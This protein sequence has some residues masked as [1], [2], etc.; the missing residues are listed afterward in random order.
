M[1]WKGQFASAVARKRITELGRVT[2]PEGT[3]DAF[4]PWA[5][6]LGITRLADITGLDYIGIPVWAAVMPNSRSLAVL[7]G[8]GVTPEAARA[9]ALMEAV[10]RYHG[11][12]VLKPVILATYNDLEFRQRVVPVDQLPRCRDGLFHAD[13]RLPWI[14][15]ADLLSMNE[16]LV[17][18]ELVHCDYTLPQVEGS[19]C[20]LAT[21]T[22]LASGNHE[23][24]ASVAALAEVIERDAVAL[25]RRL[26]AQQ[27]ARRR[28]DLA[29]VDDGTCK[30][31]L[32]L[33]TRAAIEVAVWDI[34]SNIGTAAFLCRIG[35]AS[36]NRRPR[37]GSSWG[38]G[39]HPS[40][41][42]ALLRALT[43]AAQSR[44]TVIAGARDDISSDHYLSAPIE[45]RG[46]AARHRRNP[47]KRLFSHVPTIEHDNIGE[48]LEWMIG[49][50]KSAGIHSVAR[51]DLTHESIG[52]PV[53]RMVV[54]G[55]EGMSTSPN[56][57]PGSR[58]KGRSL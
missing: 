32:E 26:N 42:I 10:E 24:E 1:G 13:F 28:L 45:R 23:V 14:A 46:S 38:V 2:S 12:H 56:Y 43:E 34:T 29:S 55:L 8:K 51:V 53:V 48:A 7:Q 58:A 15:A 21:T 16:V 50:L 30:A 4:L 17:P 33:Y 27:R 22:G 39:C 54:P 57:L 41:R 20:F 6:L 19:G 44:V 5:P 36:E 31:L 49:R 37:V 35:E 18:Y 47:V 40:R 9:S 52:I 25:F 3:L 11:E